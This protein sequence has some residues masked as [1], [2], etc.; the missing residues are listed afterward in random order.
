MNYE[1]D[2]NKMKTWEEIDVKKSLEIEDFSTL[3]SRLPLDEVEN[4]AVK[5]EYYPIYVAFIGADVTPENAWICTR[6]IFAVKNQ[7]LVARMKQKA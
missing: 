3:F 7:Q 5:N 1:N 6:N 2:R 4:I